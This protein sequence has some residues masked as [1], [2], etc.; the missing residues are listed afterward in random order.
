MV[1]LPRIVIDTNVFVA[2]LRSQRGAA[3]KL[4]SLVGTGQFE[5]TISV[6]LILEYEDA[7]KRDLRGT[8][9]TRRDVDD[10][11]DYLCSVADRRTIFF[12][13]RPFLKDPK[14]DLVLEL[15]VE[16]DCDF[17]VT[18]NKRDFAGAERFG[19]RVATA[20]EFLEARGLLR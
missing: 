12:L 8:A 3:F 4:L 11:L 5:V 19:V 10:I 15:A 6:P 2:A 14:D 7:A 16:A 9:L 17:I 18:Y 20:K 1:K 13:W